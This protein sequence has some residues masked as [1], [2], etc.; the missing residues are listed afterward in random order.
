VTSPTNG[1]RDGAGRDPGA[2]TLML[3]RRLG[4]LLAA[5][6]RLSTACLGLG[7]VLAVIRP[8]QRVATAL[9]GI[10]LVVLMATPM[11]RVAICVV[12]F[13]AERDWWFTFYTTVVFVILVGSVIVGWLG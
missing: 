6:T 4:R 1:R 9:L 8:G 11:A 5:G 12:Q 7:L 13:A 2:A 3:E 10:G